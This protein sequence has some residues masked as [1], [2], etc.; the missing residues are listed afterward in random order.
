M[1]REV[2]WRFAN[3][4]RPSGIDNYGSFCGREKS[5]TGR[6]FGQG[7]ATQFQG[8]HAVAGGAGTLV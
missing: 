5:E 1:P 7:D 4:H 8:H 3:V 6:R 2:D